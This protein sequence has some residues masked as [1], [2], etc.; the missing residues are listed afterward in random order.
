MNRI[1][2]Y[3]DLRLGNEIQRVLE[4]RYEI[5]IQPSFE[6]ARDTLSTIP[7]HIALINL[8]IDANNGLKLLRY[9][10]EKELLIIAIA[11]F[12]IYFSELVDAAS[13]WGC[14]AHLV[15]GLN[16]FANLETL[17]TQL[18]ARFPRLLTTAG[19]LSVA[20]L[21]VFIHLEEKVVSAGEDI[22]AA[23]RI[24]PEITAGQR[25]DQEERRL[26]E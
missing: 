8:N 2:L 17:L 6:E 5:N 13:R 21:E 3:D 23:W 24:C 12:D 9:I 20:T 10:Q 7:P 14:H 11:V 1:L 15:K 4:G 16:F 26:E 18:H 19:E 22:P 25:P